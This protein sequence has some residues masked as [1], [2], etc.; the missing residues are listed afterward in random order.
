MQREHSDRF[1]KRHLIVKLGAIGDVA[2]AAPAVE[3]FKRREGGQ[4]HWICGEGTSSLVRAFPFVDK[5]LTIS[6]ASLFK[7]S[8]IQRARE[9]IRIWQTLIGQSYETCALLHG[10]R[11][12]AALV[13]PIRA[14][15][16]ISISPGKN[17]RSVLIPGRSHPDEY[18]RILLNLEEP[19]T[20]LAT[21][22]NLTGHVP[23]P[24]GYART[25]GSSNRIAI[26]PGGA[27]N[28][29]RDDQQ[30]RWPLSHYVEL[31]DHAVRSGYEVALVGGPSDKWV[32][33]SFAHLRVLDTIGKF[34]VPEL[35]GFFTTCDL[36]VSH[37]TGPMH[38]AGLTDVKVLALFG[39]TN[40]DERFSKGHSASVL[41]GG[42]HLS[43]RPCYDGREF[44][45]CKDNLCMRTISPQA[46][47][48]RVAGL[49]PDFTEAS[50]RN[51]P[52]LQLY[53]G[54]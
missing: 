18:R 9:L 10:D 7:G 22:L 14:A 33:G 25:E 50:K 15:R 21:K 36:V 38:L 40:P 19:I 28:I 49:L 41:W 44:A 11:R 16:R 3:E 24:N 26:V 53:N 6:E 17:T 4:I 54:R 52:V 12:Y 43:C 5:T 13:L 51:V 47:F 39:P 42:E 32:S 35:V 37:D 2:M 45:S 48:A 29:L 30:R 31:A 27:K 46:V 34:S 1:Q 8:W 23:I 20:S